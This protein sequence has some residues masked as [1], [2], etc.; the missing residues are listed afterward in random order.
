MNEDLEISLRQ[1]QI[2]RF[3]E[4]RWGHMWVTHKKWRMRRRN[5]FFPVREDSV[6]CEYCGMF[7]LRTKEERS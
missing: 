4:Q 1:I 3:C 2:A 6:S 5:F 7:L